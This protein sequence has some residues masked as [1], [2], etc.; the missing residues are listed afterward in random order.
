M[1]LTF[2]FYKFYLVSF[3]KAFEAYIG[4]AEMMFSSETSVH[5][6]WSPES[7]LPMENPNNYEVDISLLELN[8]R[9]RI[10]SNLASLGTGLPNSG[11]ADVRIPNIQ[12]ENT[13]QQSISAV[14]VQ[15]SLSSSSIDPARLTQKGINSDFLKSLSQHTLKTI[16]NGPVRFLNKVE[17]QMIQRMLCSE[18][19]NLQSLAVLE[20]VLT[21]L[22]HCPLTLEVARLPNQGL[23]ED[24]ISSMIP[25]VGRIRNFTDTL[26]DD[27]YQQY[28]YSGTTECFH[29]RIAAGYAL[30]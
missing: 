14:V 26:V 18:W 5:V 10:W 11:S 3:E 24:R 22:I 23:R 30:P 9:T 29:Q 13:L 12:P 2:I 15:I 16:I 25:I 4:N 7:M 6:E 20:D 27:L 17:S 19:S 21:Q 1:V 8:T 28:F